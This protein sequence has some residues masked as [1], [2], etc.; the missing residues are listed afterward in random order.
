MSLHNPF[1][2]CIGALTDTAKV[3][4]MQVSNILLQVL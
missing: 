3:S 4:T 1:L 2:F